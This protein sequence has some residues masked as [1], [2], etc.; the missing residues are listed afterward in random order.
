MF[1]KS[2]GENLTPEALFGEGGEITL[3]MSLLRLR[4]DKF[5]PQR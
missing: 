1:A 5:L 4:C 2:K 3:Q